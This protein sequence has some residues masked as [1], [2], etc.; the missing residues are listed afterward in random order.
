MDNTPN[1]HLIP[2]KRLLV[3]EDDPTFQSV[4][5][6][7]LE[8]YG[9]QVVAVENGAD[10]VREVMAGDF[11]V[12]ICDMMMPKVPG[13]MFYVAVERM[14][15]YLCNRFVFITGA[16]GNQK[17]MDFI[18]QVKGLVLLK[19]FRMDELLELVSYV[20]VKQLVAAGIAPFPFLAPASNGGQAEG[21]ALQE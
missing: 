21:S 4:V 15:P 20:R 14:R 5:K 16:R 19:P 13:D 9:Y 2:P 17:V 7:Y 11:D 18:K 10:G 1:H 12:I 6:D 8:S 3:L